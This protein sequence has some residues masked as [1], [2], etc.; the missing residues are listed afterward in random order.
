[1]TTMMMIMMYMDIYISGIVR[2]LHRAWFGETVSMPKRLILTQ[3]MRMQY[4][5]FT[6]CDIALQT[7][8][9]QIDDGAFYA[10]G[11]VFGEIVDDVIFIDDDDSALFAGYVVEWE[12][13][14]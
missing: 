4:W 11:D 9:E 14:V 1:M 13:E 6:L 3:F 5:G 2:V 10:D 8:P 12:I 7:E